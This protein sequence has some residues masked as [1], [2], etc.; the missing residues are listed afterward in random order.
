MWSKWYYFEMYI[1][2][3][4]VCIRVLF[5]VI[6]VLSFKDEICVNLW[7]LFE[8][9]SM[10]TNLLLISLSNLC[11]RY[12]V[13]AAILVHLITS[14]CPL[15]LLTG[16]ETAVAWYPYYMSGMMPNKIL[17]M[18]TCS[19]WWFVVAQPMACNREVRVFSNLVTVFH[20]AKTIHMKIQK[21]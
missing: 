8:R 12:N 14:T 5:F 20:L 18:S 13:T 16:V 9:S 21:I 2:R 3:C 11:T 1:M 4:S 19:I 15:I 10:W 6:D 17:G 7:K